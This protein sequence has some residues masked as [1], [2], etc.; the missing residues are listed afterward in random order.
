M[1]KF[2]LKVLLNGLIVVSLLIWL[3]ESTFMQAIVTSIIFSTIAYFVGD[4]MILIASNNLTASVTDALLALAYFWF[5]T[6]FLQWSMAL[7]EMIIISFALGAVEFIFHRI[8]A[9]EKVR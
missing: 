9:P 2:L 5:I 4:Q 6:D 8:I 7:S 3:T 1:D